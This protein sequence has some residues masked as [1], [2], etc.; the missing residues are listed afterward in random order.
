MSTPEQLHNDTGKYFNGQPI[1]VMCERNA[2][3]HMH[4]TYY[5]QQ[6]NDAVEQVNGTVKG[7]LG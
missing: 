7:Y 6:G 5:H 2:M 3:R 1:N 4:T